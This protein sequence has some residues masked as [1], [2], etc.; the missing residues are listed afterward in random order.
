MTNLYLAGFAGL[1][2]ACVLYQAYITFI[3]NGACFGFLI[4]PNVKATEITTFAC[5]SF[6]YCL[7]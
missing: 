2:F 3:F 4:S 6:F 5:F 7:I 1:K